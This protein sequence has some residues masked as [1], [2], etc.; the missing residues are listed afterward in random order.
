[1]QRFVARFFESGFRVL[2][3]RWILSLGHRSAE[4]LQRKTAAD[5]SRRL[6]GVLGGPP[7]LARAESSLREDDLDAAILRLAYAVRCW[8]AQV[9]LAAAGDHHVAAR[10][11]EPFEGGGNGVGAPLGK[12][13]VVA[14]RS[15]SIGVAGYL[16][17]HVTA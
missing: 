9:V 15:R 2:L 4:G 8:N 10:D 12:P 6:S 14:G 11:A 7:K 5:N 17:S 1:M 16:Q 13:L 3:G